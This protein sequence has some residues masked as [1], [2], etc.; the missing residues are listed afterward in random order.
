MEIP[1]TETTDKEPRPK[2][3]PGRKLSCP[4]DVTRPV[5]TTALT[6][7]IISL[8]ALSSL[9]YGP[10]PA[11]LISLPALLLLTGLAIYKYKT[12]DRR[13]KTLNRGLRKTGEQPSEKL[14]GSKAMAAFTVL[15]N[16][17]LLSV[18]T[19][20][21]AVFIDAKIIGPPPVP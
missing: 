17:F 2:N 18:L 16:L 4:I 21:I 5:T 9:I 1:T 7:V 10:Q 13:D 11:R 14:P 19:L 12:K 15:L 8:V 20:M 6:V 3:K